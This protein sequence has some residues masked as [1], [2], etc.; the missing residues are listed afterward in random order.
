MTGDELVAE[1]WR[2]DFLES[3]H[4][5]RVVVLDPHGRQIVGVGDPSAPMYPR[6]SNKPI[7]AA[8][9]LRSGLTLDGELL[10]LA[11]ASHSGE[12]FHTDGVQQI[13]AQ[14]G[15]SI[16]DLRNTPGLPLS[17]AAMAEHV[18]AGRSAEPLT[19][20]CSGKHAA[21]LATC[22][23]AGWS[24]ENYLDPT[25]PLQQVIRQTL[26]ELAGEPVAATGVDGCGAPLLAVSLTGLARA[27]GRIATAP[28]GSAEARVAA[29]MRAHPQYV[30]GTDR[31]VTDLMRLV[32]GLMAKDGAEGVYAGALPDGRA[33]ALKIADGSSRARPPVM[34]AA[35]RRLGADLAGVDARPAETSLTT[36][37][38][39]GHGV[40]VGSVRVVAGLLD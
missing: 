23:A 30:G 35:L 6:S 36:P 3:T 39:L 11:A 26:E 21:M 19:M 13:L 18:G 7:Q 40:P 4:H 32:P 38:V 2:G 16:A 34:I 22:V 14:A 31:D 17:N 1:V 15:L 9:M 28:A 20:N 37:P 8:A 29:A 33:V 25:H 5:G 24:T 12:K 27:F 10:A